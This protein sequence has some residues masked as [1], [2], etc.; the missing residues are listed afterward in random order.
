MANPFNVA[1]L[2]AFSLTSNLQSLPTA[3][4]KGLGSLGASVT[5]YYDDNVAPITIRSGVSGVSASGTVSF[6]LVCSEDGTNWTNGINPNATTDQAG[7]LTG[8]TPLQPVLGVVANAT[9]YIFPEF[10]VYSILGFMPS[11]WA[12]VVLNQSGAALDATLTN[13]YA[14]HSLVSYA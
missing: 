6:F 11:F 8:L 13:F 7:S 4:A 2:T 3:Q 5:Q 1:A 14:R 9:N 12:L 10:S